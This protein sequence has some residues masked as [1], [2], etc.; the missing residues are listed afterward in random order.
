MERNKRMAGTRGSGRRKTSKNVFTTKSGNVIKLNRS[1]GER[2]RAKRE[3]KVRKRAAYLSSLPKNRF[4]RLLYRMHPKRLYKYW[5]SREGLIM[6]L[7]VTGIGL[8]ACFLLL[9]GV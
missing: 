4:K 5:F 2:L 1:F 8:V 3:A 7:K 6:A 9:V